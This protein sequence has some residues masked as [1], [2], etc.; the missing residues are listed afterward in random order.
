MRPEVFSFLHPTHN[1]LCKFLWKKWANETAPFQSPWAPFIKQSY[2]QG[3]CL[4]T[5]KLQQPSY[6]NRFVA[7]EVIL[8][9]LFFG[10]NQWLMEWPVQQ[11]T[12]QVP[13][14]CAVSGFANICPFFRKQIKFSLFPWVALMD[15]N[16]FYIA[17][18][19]PYEASKHLMR[20][21]MS[22]SRD[23]WGKNLEGLF[24]RS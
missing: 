5:R 18:T 23:R 13:P 3:G 10:V 19:T 9:H 24:G 4:N 21:G 16:C 20:L 12:A 8:Q 15:S 2:G 6:M 11:Q 22:Q 14:D 1:Q 17:L 7:P